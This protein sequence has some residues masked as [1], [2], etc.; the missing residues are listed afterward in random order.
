ML[1]HSR[2]DLGDE[3][4]LWWRKLKEGDLL[5]DLGIDGSKY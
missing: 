1:L 2:Y 5:E 3:C 4:G